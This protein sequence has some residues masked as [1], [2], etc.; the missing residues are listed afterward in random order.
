MLESFLSNIDLLIVT[1]GALV[2]IAA[3]LMG[4]FLVLRGN[5]MLTDAISH[6]VV[7]GIVVV[8]LLTG[9]V[10]GPV[11]IV[12]AALT[13]LLTVWLTE[14]V[15]SSGRVKQDAAI[16]LVFPV[17]FAAGVLLM[18]IYARNVHIDQHT[19][20]LGEIGFIWLD[21]LELGGYHVPRSL[22]TMSLMTLIN[23]LFVTLLFKELKLATFDR[24]LARALGFAPGVLSYLLLG[25]TS[26]TAVTAFDAVGAVMFVAFAIVPPSTARLLT[27]RLV[28]M[29]VAG[30]AV[31]ILASGIGYWLAT[32]LNVS[33]GGMMATVAG[34]LLLLA[35]LFSPRTGLVWRMA[36]RLN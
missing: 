31:A 10:S 13:G 9:A 7:F 35:F 4:T 26:A 11:Q 12:G 1:T 17:M 33:I 21:T 6:S 2:G 5:G 8:W 34:V 24:G 3:S 23:L 28:P 18:N 30:S 32:A 19:V 36:R 22:L 27:D 29:M 25:L 20:L 14:L 16:G 15:A